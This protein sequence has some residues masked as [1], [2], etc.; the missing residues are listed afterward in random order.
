[1]D[2]L[3]AAVRRVHRLLEAIRVRV[4]PQEGHWI[5][6]LWQG[7]AQQE[8]DRDFVRDADR[9][10]IQQEPLRARILLRALLGVALLFVLWSAVVKIDE[11]TKGDGKVIPS[12]QLQVLQSLDGGIVS[13]IAVTE[14]QQVEAGQLLL[15][16]DS[17]RFES[18]ARE[19]RA[20]YLSLAARAARLQAIGEG[21]PFSPDPEVAKEDPKTVAEERELYETATHELNAQVSI[22]QQQMAQRQQ[23]LSEARA[24]QAQAAQAYELAAKEYSV[25]KPLLA[26]GAVSEVDLLRLERDVARFKGERDVAAAQIARAQAAI[27]EASRKIQ[28]VELNVRNTARKEYSE[29][30]AKMNAL[31]QS[32]TGLNDRVKQSAIRSPVKGTVKRLLVNTVGGVVQPGRDIVEIVP[33]EDQLVL[34][35]RVLPKDI[36]FLRPGQKAMVKFTA[37]DFSIYGGL[38]A[39]LEHIGADSVT[40]ERGNTFYVV[41][42]RTVK[43]HLGANLPIIPGMVAEVDIITGEKSILS[44]LMKPVLRAKQGALTER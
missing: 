29:T 21:T 2:R 11:V 16:I 15:Q 20:Q 30:M 10:M 37:Y 1:M 38:E 35:A 13:Q 28:E 5:Y 41:R 39:T 3:I 27:A 8:A 14:G 23:E 24:R 40:D 31:A 26:S 32:S 42:V 34:E 33:S 7:E 43:S 6:R 4:Q 12:R 22:A 18:S 19:N 17:T 25:T 36:A 9:F 44:Y